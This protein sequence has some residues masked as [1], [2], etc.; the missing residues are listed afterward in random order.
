MTKTA[1]KLSKPSAQPE[2]S[3]S[4]EHIAPPNLFKVLLEG[5]AI[6]EY[7]MTLATWPFMH[8][9]LSDVHR[10]DGHPVVVFPGLAATDLTTT[11]LR[12]FL[13]K[14]GYDA[15]PWLQGINLGP[16]PGVLEIATE[17][18][19]R[20]FKTTGKKVSVVG[21][22]LGGIYAREIAKLAP[23]AVRNVI[24]LGTP[25][26]GSPDATNAFWLYKLANGKSPVDNAL[27]ESLKTSPPVPTTSIYSKSD[28]I[29]AWQC[30]IQSA[31]R[32]SA[33]FENIELIASHFG[34]GFNA[35]AW[36]VI[37]DRL[38]QV[39]GEWKKFDINSKGVGKFFYENSR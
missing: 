26:E 21:W 33:E 22:S 3:E 27:R 10:G 15:H 32:A 2:S 14:I 11:P 23:H 12:A 36:Y 38:S 1:S 5:R 9:A 24:T 30:S 16:R 29:V 4:S 19:E 6:W 31:K 17:Q 8:Y 34:I 25:F 39:E 18:V 20:I 37:A 7:G 35:L 13:S 28:G